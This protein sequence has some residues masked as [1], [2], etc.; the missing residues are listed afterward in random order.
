MKHGHE[1]GCEGRGRW[2]CVVAHRRGAGD[3]PAA[4]DMLVNLPPALQ[5]VGLTH[6][7]L[8]IRG[9][10]RNTI[11]LLDLH[12]ITCNCPRQSRR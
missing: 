7:F 5:H 12:G 10:V 2:K 8:C 1:W 4:G 11:W 3:M 9:P 6:L